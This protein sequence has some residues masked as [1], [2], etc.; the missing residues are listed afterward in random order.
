MFFFNFSE[1]NNFDEALMND[2]HVKD[3]SLYQRPSGSFNQY[4]K[5][6]TFANSYPFQYQ[7]SNI[8]VNDE[9]KGS[10][11]ASIIFNEKNF[12]STNLRRSR[13]RNNEPSDLRQSNDY[14]ASG[15]HLAKTVYTYPKNLHVKRNKD[16]ERGVSFKSD[17]TTARQ[18]KNLII[19]PM[20]D[21][22]EEEENDQSLSMKNKIFDNRQSPPSYEINQNPFFCDTIQQDQNHILLPNFNYP[23]DSNFQENKHFQPSKILN[24]D[25]NNNL[26]PKTVLVPVYQSVPN[27]QHMT[28]YQE[29][30]TLSKYL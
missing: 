25:L 11:I 30:F 21:V 9:I 3:R 14:K 22:D 28:R 1:E 24:F 12:D 6:P 15:S 2:F 29:P 17:S 20:Q 19:I 7:L 18:P 16:E 26:L 23:M 4:S 13:S 10:D 5:K 8:Q 27:N